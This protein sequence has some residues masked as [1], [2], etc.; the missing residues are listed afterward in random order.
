MS[1]N[2]DGVPN[3]SLQNWHT[4]IAGQRERGYGFFEYL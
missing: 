1:Y 2:L 4:R 3:R